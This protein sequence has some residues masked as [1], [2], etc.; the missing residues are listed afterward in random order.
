MPFVEEPRQKKI[1]GKE[2]HRGDSDI[3]RAK[4]KQ[5]TGCK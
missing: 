5:Q 1:A 2:Q 4:R 3:E